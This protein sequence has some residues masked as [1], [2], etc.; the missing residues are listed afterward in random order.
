MAACCTVG[1]IIQRQLQYPLSLL[2]NDIEIYGVIE[3]RLDYRSIPI[4]ST[5]GVNRDLG[6]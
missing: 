2:A 6:I 3:N 4:F 5:K 1:A